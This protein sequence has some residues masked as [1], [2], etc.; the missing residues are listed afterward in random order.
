MEIALEFHIWRVPAASELLNYNK[1]LSPI[2]FSNRIEGVLMHRK[3][4]RVEWEELDNQMSI[5]PP[6][7]DS[8]GVPGEHLKLISLL[9]RFGFNPMSKSEAMRLAERLLDVGW[10]DQSKLW[11]NRP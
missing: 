4:T 6:E 9:N 2:K 5:T 10:E 3:L 8:E 7:P 1:M 11:M